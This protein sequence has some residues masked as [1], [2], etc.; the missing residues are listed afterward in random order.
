MMCHGTANDEL[1]EGG[2]Y[3]RSVMPLEALGRTR[4]TMA[5]SVR[6]LFDR[7]GYPR[8]SVVVRTGGCNC[9]PRMRNF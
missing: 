2:G 9:P 4:D 1:E 3:N 7:N 5:V 8:I 6:Y